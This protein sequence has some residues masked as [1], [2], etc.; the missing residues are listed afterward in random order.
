MS[1]RTLLLIRSPTLPEGERAVWH[2][3]LFR[4]RDFPSHG[5]DLYDRQRHLE[6]LPAAQARMERLW[7]RDVSIR[8]GEHSGMTPGER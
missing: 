7:G 3:D 2:W 6:R 5:V 1:G 4:T 8:T